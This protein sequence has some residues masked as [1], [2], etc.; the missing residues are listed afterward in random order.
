MAT[1]LAIGGKRLE[2]WPHD[3]IGAALDGV[4]GDLGRRNLAL[5]QSFA[6]TLHSHVAPR[7]GGARLSWGQTLCGD[8]GP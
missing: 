6:K 2:V 4:I 1:G 8:C 5:A 7:P 3:G